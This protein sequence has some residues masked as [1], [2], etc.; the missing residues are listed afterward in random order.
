MYPHSVK[1]QYRLI[2]FWVAEK[3]NQKLGK[4]S[5]YPQSMYP[6]MFSVPGKRTMRSLTGTK[7]ARSEKNFPT[8][9]KKKKKNSNQ[10]WYLVVFG[11]RLVLLGVLVDQISTFKTYF[12][13]QIIYK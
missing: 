13:D 5:M 8:L 4:K 1:E 2:Y 6:Q 10:C 9:N 7:H 3:T 12:S 11:S